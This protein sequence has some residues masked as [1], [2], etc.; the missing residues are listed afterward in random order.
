MAITEDSASAEW[1]TEGS[2]EGLA[3][4]TFGRSLYTDIIDLKGHN[5]KA[6]NQCIKRLTDEKSGPRFTL[7]LIFVGQRFP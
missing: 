2:A 7:E 1:T 6:S 5:N 3:E 4:G